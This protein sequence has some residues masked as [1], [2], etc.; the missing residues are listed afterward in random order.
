MYPDYDFAFAFDHSQGHAK[1][2][3]KGLLDASEINA[4]YGGA[5]P[6]AHYAIN[7]N[8]G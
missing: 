4:G 6:T 2:R 1:K 5:Q 7:W 8:Q 3:K